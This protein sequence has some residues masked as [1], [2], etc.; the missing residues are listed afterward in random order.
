MDAVTLGMAKAYAK[1]VG[2]N[3]SNVGRDLIILA[4]Q[5]NMSGRGA[6]YD[7][8]RLD[9]IDQTVEQFGT[10]GT[11]ANQISVAVEPLAMHDVPSGIGPGRVFAS[12]YRQ[13]VPPNRRVLLVPVARGSTTFYGGSGYTWLVGGASG[14][15]NLYANMITQAKAALA[16]A[17]PN[18]R[19]VAVL[20]V[21]GESDGTYLTSQTNYRNALDALIDA[22][23]TD[24]G[25]ADL[26]FVIGQ[27][28]YE[29]RTDAAQF[30]ADVLAAR[31][32]IDGVQVD[33]PR[34]KTRT[35]FAYGPVGTINSD[36]LHYNAPGQRI[37]GRSMFSAY[38]RAAANVAGSLPVAVPAPVITQTGSAS[39]AVTWEQSVGRVT[40]YTLQY[41][42]GAGSWQNVSPAAL[43]AVTAPITGL[44]VGNTISARVVTTNDAGSATSPESSYTLLSPPGQVTGLT[45]GTPTGT[46]QPLSWT[47]VSGATAYLVEYR[48]SAGSW[49]TFG[50]VG[51]AAATVSG[52]VASTAYDYR[53]S[54]VNGAG[55]GT[56]S[57]TVTATTAEV[58]ADQTWLMDYR[59]S[60]LSALSDN[61]AVASWPAHSGAVTTGALA[62]ATGGKQ[63]T[64][65]APAGSVPA[66]V[67]FAGA[68]ALAGSALGTPQAQPLTI[69]C[70]FRLNTIISSGSG[71]ARVFDGVD[72]TNEVAFHNRFSTNSRYTGYAGAQVNHASVNANT[73]WRIVTMEIRAS[74]DASI[75]IDGS[76][77][78]T[79][80]LGA[81]ALGGLTLGARYDQTGLFFDGDIGE[82]RVAAGTVSDLAA[83]RAA[84]AT[85]YGVT[86]V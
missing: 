23:R 20:W 56:A 25:I 35:A 32:A 22:T 67:R 3:E 34:R 51:A 70:A 50:T 76:E 17:G 15:V 61:A 28:P 54:A 30:A 6:A 43:L 26:P 82:I 42:I 55:A 46:T 44:A 49:A 85:K 63:P 8:T 78:V 31:V 24:L 41:R 57:S 81:N 83:I 10:S 33:T 13:S 77:T 36:K 27:I 86:L 69:I 18:S 39:A 45:A 59:A 38:L 62:Q 11:W 80:A 84:M 74:N 64:Y 47:A 16:A 73:A 60:D 9:P 53:V 4:G 58:G 48:V 7:L 71:V 40:G 66:F 12:W 1:K 2:V 29:C 5:S 14:K 68:H 19:I 65:K 79:A 72:A 75:N 37:L 21:Q 52:L